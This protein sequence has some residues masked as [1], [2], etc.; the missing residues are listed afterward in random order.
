MAERQAQRRFLAL[1]VG[2]VS[3]VD[4]PANE[5]EFIV[6]KRL[7]MEE[8]T[9]AD[10]AKVETQ[11]APAPAATA[12]TTEAPVTK[13]AE[14]A[15]V[16]VPVEV[17]KTND[18]NV[19]KALQQVEQLTTAIAKMM[20]AAPADASE[21]EVE[22]AKAS[23]ATAYRKALKECGMGEDEL[24]GAMKALMPWMKPAKPGAKDEEPKPGEKGAKKEVK[25]S[26]DGDSAEEVEMSK[27]LDALATAI[28]KAKSFTP[29]REAALKNAIESLSKLLGDMQAP[30]L[31][32]ISNDTDPKN[33]LPDGAPVPSGLEDV[34]KAVEE[35]TKTLKAS[36]ETATTVTKTLQER[37]E[38]IEKARNPSTSLEAE[39]A[40]DKKVTKSFWAN[41]L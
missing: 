12:A 11:A 13:G 9:M 6:V 32:G 2:E 19:Q 20:G 26:T 34:K 7:D 39:G 8:S 40:T 38:T 27:T 3:L 15:A 17:T 28:Q 30:S 35:L 5:Q 14:G 33:N 18:E 29:K 10:V 1:K 41:V 22:K 24:D 16:V 21:A 4:S 36:F 23:K 31:P 37:V 25:K